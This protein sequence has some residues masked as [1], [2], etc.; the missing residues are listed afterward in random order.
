MIILA[1]YTNI[2][3]F[4]DKALRAISYSGITFKGPDAIQQCAEIAASYGFKAF[5]VQYGGQCFTGP[6]A[7]VTYAKYGK[8][9]DSDCRN[10]LGGAWRN[11]VYFIGKLI[12]N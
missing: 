2:G 3:C 10:G 7:H 4:V 1:R 8:A 12:A 5:G 9:S 11:N 6:E